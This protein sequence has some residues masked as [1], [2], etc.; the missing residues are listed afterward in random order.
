MAG[1]PRAHLSALKAQYSTQC[2]LV[3]LIAWI[4]EPDR[5]GSWYDSATDYLIEYR[6]FH[7]Q[8]KGFDAQ[9]TV[10]H[11]HDGL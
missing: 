4:I 1:C 2:S 9:A 3:S 10:V 7:L 11:I 8:N 5:E 6:V